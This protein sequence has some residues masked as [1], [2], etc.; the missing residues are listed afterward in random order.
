MTSIL[1]SIN[2]TK[3]ELEKKKEWYHLPVEKLTLNKSYF[4]AKNF[5][6]PPDYAQQWEEFNRDFKF[7]QATNYRAFSETLLSLLYRYAS[8]IPAST[9]HFPD[10]SLYD[11]SKMAAALAVCL[12][13]WKMDEKKNEKPFLL[14]GA[15]FSGIQPY[16]YQVVSKYAGKNLK[17][18]SFYLRILSDAVARFLLKELKLFQSNI[19]YNSGGSFYILAPNTRFVREKLDQAVRKI[20]KNMFHSHGT[21]LY[22]AIE[23]IEVS[24]EALMNQDKENLTD[25][26]GNLFVKRD[27]KKNKK[28]SYLVSN[29]YSQFFEPLSIGLETDKITGEAIEKGEATVEIK[30]I[31]SVKKLTYQ[32]VEL[33]KRLRESELLIISDGEIQYWK[34]QN[35]IQPI[36]LGFYFYLIKRDEFKKLKNDLKGSADFI[37]V[38]T[39]NGKDGNCDFLHTDTQQNETIK[40]LNN[41]YGLDFYGGNLFDGKTFDEFCDKESEDVFRRLGVLRMDVDNLGSIFQKGIIRERVTLSRMAALSRSFDYFFTGYINTIQQKIAPDTSFIVYS[42][43]DD[44]FIVASWED[45]IRLAKT[46]RDEFKDFTCNNPAFSLSGGIAIITPKY[47]VMKGAKDSDAEEREAKEHKVGEAKKNALSFM[48][49][50]LNWNCEFEVVEQAKNRIVSLIKKDDDGTSHCTNPLLARFCCI[51]RMLTSENTRSVN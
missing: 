9:I 34:N 44:L 19:I 22:L 3:E 2:L 20:E 39:L 23:S 27:E 42:G 30:E 38:I 6:R 26:W 49:T 48:N 29:S 32:Q 15:D 7:I 28:F 11:H 10:V 5:E 14:I 33:G 12:Y 36:D 24:K 18:R 16:I 13:D 50:P 51:M 4:P 17:G 37:H 45:A 41:V 25:L 47:P 35:P 21:S 43:G 40:G 46:I 1:E 31:G 8:N